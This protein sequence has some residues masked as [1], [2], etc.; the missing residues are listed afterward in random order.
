[1]IPK[2]DIEVLHTSTFSILLFFFF[3]GRGR[4]AFKKRKREGG[5]FSPLVNSFHYFIIP[6]SKTTVCPKFIHS[7]VEITSSFLAY[8]LHPL[9]VRF[10]NILASSRLNSHSWVVRSS[11][12]CPKC[13]VS[14][15]FYTLRSIIHLAEIFPVIFQFWLNTAIL[16]AGIHMCTQF[17]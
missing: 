15:Q 9:F 16:Y 5:T 3:S 13:S 4:W 1:M 2:L 7:Q 12:L 11:L 6:I 8:F 14:I 10:A 17:L